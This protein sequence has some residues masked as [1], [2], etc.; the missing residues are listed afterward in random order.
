M[1]KETTI[2][3][4]EINNIAWKACDTFRGVVDPA[5]YKNYILVFL[6]IKYISDVW[7][8]KYEQ[9]HQMYNG[10]EERIDRRLKRERFIV[11]K[12][13]TFDYIF[14]NRNKDNIFII[15]SSY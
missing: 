12:E 7:K 15:R 13:S 4:N 6:F 2:T 3:Q 10:N 14:N 9:Y 8:D 5:E 1:L 11:P